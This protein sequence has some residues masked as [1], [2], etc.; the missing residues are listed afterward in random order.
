MRSILLT[1][2]LVSITAGVASA[3]PHG[4]HPSLLSLRQ[5][6]A[7]HQKAVGT[8]TSGATTE[9]DVVLVTADGMTGSMRTVYLGRDFR[10]DLERGEI[11]S[12]RGEYRGIK[13]HQN[14]NGIVVLDSNIHKEDTINSSARRK[15]DHGFARGAELLGMVD[16]PVHAYVLRIDPPSGRKEYLYYDA[17]TFLLVRRE[18]Q[19]EGHEEITTYSDFRTVN[20]MTSAWHIHS[21][22]VHH[23]NIS[24]YVVQS[25]T[26]GIHVDPAS[27]TIPASAPTHVALGASKA[28]IPTSFDA[29]RIIV[30]TTI[31]HHKVDLLLDSGSSTVLLNNAVVKALGIKIVGKMSETAGGRFSAG[32]ALLP[33]M[34]IGSAVASNLVVQT[35]PFEELQSNGEPI[36]G[37]LGFD[38]LYGSVVH[39]DY[40]KHS[41]ELLDPASFVPP[42]GARVLAVAD[43]DEVPVVHA[44]IA[45]VLGTNFIMDTGAD[46][47]M[48]FQHFVLVHPNA[49]RDQGLGRQIE[50]AWPA[51]ATIGGVGGTFAVQE[52]QVGAL[53][54]A[55]LNL[56][57]WLVYLAKNAPGFE[58][59]DFDGLIG[60][61][62]LRFFDV[63]LDYSHLKVYLVPNERYVGR[64]GPAGGA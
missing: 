13:W 63:Y 46:R 38:A 41:V 12:S 15:L 31:S 27:L 53:G 61:D 17:A 23:F 22:D 11:H 29:D 8:S 34:K 21:E 51:S 28:L 42:V 24:D 52:R 32:F 16:E 26:P 33:R 2:A 3:A 57:N 6:V 5:V 7:N 36:A 49:V 64:F 56:P 19:I 1:V 62:A 59:E 37:L 4:V 20:N 30:H 58:H 45:G 55:G 35:A 54:L 18:Y 43:G 10:T 47:S 50:I 39:I 40:M 9:L 25:S 60:Q 44:A 48:V 14:P